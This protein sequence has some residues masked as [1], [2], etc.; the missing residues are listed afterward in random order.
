MSKLIANAHSRAE[1]WNPHYHD[2]DFKPKSAMIFR[3]WYVKR[4]HGSVFHD[5]ARFAVAPL[6]VFGGGTAC[7]Y[8]REASSMGGTYA[9]CPSCKTVIMCG[10]LDD[11]GLNPRA[12]GCGAA[13]GFDDYFQPVELRKPDGKKAV[14]P[15]K[16]PAVTVAELC[17][18]LDDGVPAFA[19]A[20]WIA[21]LAAKDLLKTGAFLDVSGFELRTSGLESDQL[22]EALQR[23]RWIWID[24]CTRHWSVKLSDRGRSMLEARGIKPDARARKEIERLRGLIDGG[25]DARLKSEAVAALATLLDR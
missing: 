9:V 20:P 21:I 24:P 14:D 5:L 7:E 12:C 16:D 4:Y 18:Y 22:R 15:S 6:C 13:L 17:S 10:Y 25:A 1:C 23:E 3:R 2:G 11:K 8:T 19:L